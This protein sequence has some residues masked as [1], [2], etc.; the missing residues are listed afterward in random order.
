MRIGKKKSP[1]QRLV[2]IDS[3]RKQNSKYLDKVGF[4]DPM[5]EKNTLTIDA[6][7][8]KAWQKKGAIMSKGVQKLLTNFI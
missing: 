1:K 4:Y 8:V 3:Q 2:V 5:L 6:E 7:K